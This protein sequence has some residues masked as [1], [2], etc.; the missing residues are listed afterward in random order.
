MSMRGFRPWVVWSVGLFAYLVGVMNRTTFGV[1][2]LDAADRF[3]AA[4]ALLSGFRVRSGRS[5]PPI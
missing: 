5:S 3:D 2:G 1:A 4:P